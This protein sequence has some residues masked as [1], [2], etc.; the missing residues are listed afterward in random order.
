MYKNVSIYLDCNTIVDRLQKKVSD[1]KLSIVYMNIL[2][3]SIS[4]F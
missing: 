1:R 4:V 3:N 2:F